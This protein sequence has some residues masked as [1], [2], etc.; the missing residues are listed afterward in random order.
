MRNGQKV[1]IQVEMI[2][3]SQI[4]KDYFDIYASLPEGVGIPGDIGE[5]KQKVTGEL[6]TDTISVNAIHCDNDKYYIYVVKEQEGI[7]GKEYYIERLLV[8]IIDKNDNFAAIEKGLLSEDMQ[9]VI[10]SD[11]EI[12]R[13]DIVRY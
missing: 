5:F 10:D 1:S 2:T 7:L 8:K 12:E 11:K 13:G 9:I 6:Y 4:G 3:Q